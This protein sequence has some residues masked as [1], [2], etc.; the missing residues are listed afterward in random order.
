MM[1]WIAIAALLLSGAVHAQPVHVGPLMVQNNLSEIAAAG[2]AAQLAARN[3]LGITGGG[4]SFLP[5]TGGTV[6]G[7]TTFSGAGTGLAVPNN[8]TVGSLNGYAVTLGVQPNSN[9]TPATA[10]TGNAI[11]DAL[12]LNDGCATHATVAVV[13]VTSGGVTSYNVTGAG[14]CLAAPAN[15]VSVSSTTGTGT[16]ATFTLKWGPTFPSGLLGGLFLGNNGNMFLSSESPNPGFAGTENTFVG[17]RAGSSFTGISFGDTAIGH[18]ACGGGS[19]APSAGS[20]NF[21]G[22]GD[23]FRNIANSPGN[24]TGVGA[25]S[26]KAQVHAANGLTYVG[27]ASGLNNNDTWNGSHTSAVGSSSCAGASGSAFGFGNCF[28]ANTGAALTTAVNFLIVGGGTST[29]GN[30]TFA[31]GSG[32]ILMGSGGQTVDTPAAGTSNYINIENILTVTGTG[33]PSTSAAVFAGSLNGMFLVGQTLAGGGNFYF[34]QETATSGISGTENTFGGDR[35]GSSFTGASSFD[36]AFGHNA[37]GGGSGAPSAGSNNS[38]GGADSFRN[39]AN[40]SNN[41]TGWGSNAGKAQTLGVN[42]LTYIGAFSGLNNNDPF[43]GSHTT[44]MG[45]S[46]CAGAVG[47]AFGFGNCFGANTGGVLTTAANFLI[48]GG[49]S[50]VVGNTTFASGSGVILVGSGGQTVDTPAGNTSNYI[51]IENILTV[52]GTNTPST[53]IAK[54]AG[55]FQIGTAVTTL[56]G[57]EFGLAKISAS[58][59]APGAGTGKLALVAGTTGG[60]CKLIMYAGTSTAPTTIIDNV[61]SGC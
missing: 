27:S 38:C 14:S 2:A 42:G 61:G 19:N 52:T 22:G 12:T 17:D 18:N 28:G 25:N 9:P 34:T 49:G 30:T 32:V 46:S 57:N 40:A 58:G 54:F 59:S 48:I 6:T 23:S 15:P 50:S 24:L 11:G 44:A 16:G 60:T 8:A 51:N 33:T 53:S 37:C 7:L 35:A 45:L 55:A 36:T 4:G 29:V 13:A 31:S 21:C 5:L 1:K 43:S 39:L 56:A 47:S 26:G 41:V 20:N 3:N 10:G